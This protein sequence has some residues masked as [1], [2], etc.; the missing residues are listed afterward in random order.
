MVISAPT[1][2]TW[3]C[4]SAPPT[5]SSSWTWRSRGLPGGRYAGAGNGLTTGAGCGP[6]GA[7][8]CRRSGPRSP[9]APPAPNCLS[10][11]APAWSATSSAHCPICRRLNCDASAADVAVQQQDEDDFAEFVAA[12]VPPL[13]PVAWVPLDDRMIQWADVTWR[14]P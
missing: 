8:T 12:L 1:I 14:P 2:R 10:C 9:Q 5:P 11:A 6:T 3:G 7:G 13:A 4:G